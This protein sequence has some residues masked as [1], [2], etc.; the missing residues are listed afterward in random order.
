M[1]NLSI[2]KQL[3]AIC[4]I[5]SLLTTAH[6]APAQQQAQPNI[7]IF[8]VDDLGWRDLGCYGSTFYQTPRIDQLAGMGMRFTDAYAACTV[9]SPTR[10]SIMTGQYPAR[11]HITDWI[12]GHQAGSGPQPDQRFLVPDFRQQLPLEEVTIAEV[13]RK[14]GYATASIGKWHLGGE[15]FL[16]QDQGFDV[17]IAGNHFG[18]PPGYFA[19]YQRKSDNYTLAGLNKTAQKGEYLTDQLTVES[20][21]FIEQHQDQPFFLYLSH[22][23]VHTPLQAK[24]DLEAK[25]EKTASYYDP[26]HHPTYAAMVESVD[27]SMG[28]LLDKLQAL[29]VLDNTIIFFTSDN[30]GLVHQ[31]PPPT[32][33][34][35]FRS[36]K[37]DVYE[38]G[39]RVPLIVYWP[40]K[41][42]PQTLSHEAVISCDL[43]PTIEAMLSNKDSKKVDGVSLAKL[44]ASGEPLQR[45]KPLFWHYPHYHPG[46]ATPYSAIREGDWKLIEFFED[47]HLELYDLKQDIGEKVNLVDRFPE[48]AKALHQQLSAWRQETQA[49]MPT[50]R[51]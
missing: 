20:E 30:G 49:Q 18:Q 40:E 46:G 11:L 4:L 27:H 16:P 25:Y 5:L 24:K 38:G 21:K 19:P 47:N 32:S 9:C 1:K 14:Q 22:Y 17:N 34:D 23:A 50:P 37:G 7:I 3:P 39:T 10:A 26:Q 29:N 41:T 31:Y 44:L 42:K 2:Y 13:L 36:G 51:K 33:N 6:E 48:K 45:G 12:P 28:R 8:L 35:P 43:F 15:G